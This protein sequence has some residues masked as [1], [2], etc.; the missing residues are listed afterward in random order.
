M[1]SQLKENTLTELGREYLNYY[2]DTF[3]SIEATEPLGVA[4][5][6]YENIITVSEKYEISEF[7]KNGQRSI[8]ADRIDSELRKPTISKR[9][10]PLGIKYPIS[11]EQTLEFDMPVNI[12][13]LV[14]PLTTISMETDVFRLEYGVAEGGDHTSFHYK[15]QTL[16][17]NVPATNVTKHLADLEKARNAIWYD[18]REGSVAGTLT[19]RP[20]SSS[21]SFWIPVSILGLILGPLVLIGGYR[22]AKATRRRNDFKGKFELARGD[23]ASTAIPLQKES[24]L[25]THLVNYKCTCGNDYRHPGAIER[26]ALIF[27]GR[28]L[29]VVQLKCSSCG[30]SRDV[31]FAPESRS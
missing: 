25:F 24:D 22:A 31:Y 27:D 29:I 12:A 26:E 3:P 23:A 21:G 5:D 9:A 11:I 7:W 14:V 16:T 19:I 17:D 10:W 8:F 2:A 13:A 20:Q 1:R 30:R 15:F 6:Q 4:D 28:R 18:L